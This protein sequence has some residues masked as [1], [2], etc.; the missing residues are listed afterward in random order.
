MRR[1]ALAA[2]AACAAATAIATAAPAVAQ[3]RSPFA[4]RAVVEGAYGPTW[5]HAARDRVLRWFPR[6]GFNAYVHAPK[7]DLYQRTN[8]R[9]PYPAA[10]QAEFDA[11]IR[12]ARAHGIEWIPNLSPALPLIPTPAAPRS[13][14]SRDLCFS[15]PDDLRAV[16]DKLEPFR[17][18]GARTFMISFDD[19]TKT[20]THP[21]DL[22]AYGA[23]DQAFGRANGDFLSRLLAALGARTPGARLLT[24]GA[25]YSGTAD[26]AY[27]QGL[28]ATLRP[29]VEVMWTGNQ[30]PSHEFAPADAAAYGKLIGR[31]PLVWDNWT[32]DDTAGNA[33][34]LGTARIFLGPYL[35]RADVAGAVGGFFLNPMNE[36]D[37]NMLPLAT[38]GDWM[39]NPAR[40]RRRASWLRAVAELAGR[41]RAR[42]AVRASLRAWA[43]TSWSTKLDLLEAPTFVRLNRAFLKAYGTR[44]D[45]GR[46]RRRL[47]T[48]LSLAAAAGARLAG[49]ANR[50]FALQARAFLDAAR[51]A[52]GAGRLGTALLAAERPTLRVRATGRGRRGAFTGSA[53]P[54]DPD[55]AA[56]LR[57]RYQPQRDESMR[58]RYFTYGWRTPYAFE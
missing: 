22:A 3:A 4:W 37:L 29:E 56:T 41:G 53:K 34:P 23:G 28:R 57:A 44:P 2:A 6:H 49:L 9:D 7:D 24:V 5:D 45:W 19:V 12:F 1:L 31:R 17:R 38:A 36:A 32:D 43:E 14:P 48:E 13:P 27:L 33:T 11:E 15:C 10:Q 8:W 26:T 20:L 18:A 50:D 51:Q 46:A 54:P 35:R 39:R 30:V 25:D 47:D 42:K 40:Y 58:S 52:A 55:A 16:L 21:E